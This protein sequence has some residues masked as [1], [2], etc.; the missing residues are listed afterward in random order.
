M[1]ELSEIEVA[2]KKSKT[3]WPSKRAQKYYWI[4][5]LKRNGKVLARSSEMYTNHLDCFNAALST[6]KNSVEIHDFNGWKAT[7]HSRGSV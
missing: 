6:F 7:F 1:T 3:K 5:T 2:V 4:A